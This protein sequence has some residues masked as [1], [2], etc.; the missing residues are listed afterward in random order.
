MQRG[1]PERMLRV[2]A[3]PVAVSLYPTSPSSG[4][5]MAE[6]TLGVAAI[7]LNLDIDSFWMY[8]RC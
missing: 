8:L 2:E 5:G 1:F 4:L 3:D 6:P 7:S